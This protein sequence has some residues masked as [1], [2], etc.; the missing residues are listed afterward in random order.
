MVASAEASSS[1][2][3]ASDHESQSRDS[4]DSGTSFDTSMHLKVVVVVALVGITYDFG[5]STMTKTHLGSLRNHSRNFP[6]G[7]G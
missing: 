3:V 6:K 1:R 7:Y 5:Q 2:E 4:E